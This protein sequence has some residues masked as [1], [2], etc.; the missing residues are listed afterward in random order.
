M[1]RNSI[2]ILLV[3]A[4]LASCASEPEWKPLNLLEYG[5]PIII[6]SPDSPVIKKMDLVFQQD[7]SVKKGDYYYVQIFS[8]EA[9]TRNPAELKDQLKEEV[10]NNPFFSEIVQDD[11]RGFIYK[12]QIDSSNSTYGFRF[13]EI[14]G[15]KEYV[16]QTG[17]IGA[18]TEE[19]V[20]SMY[21][22]VQYK[23]K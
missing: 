7:I 9:S 14:K 23:S 1:I 20:R 18:Y 5:M 2:F 13:V 6:L 12:D 17:L 19:E 15:D 8:G 3:A 22:A 4:I 16:F 11:E 10:L 21:D